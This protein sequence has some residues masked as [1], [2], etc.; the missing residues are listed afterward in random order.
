MKLLILGAGNAQLNAI[1]RAKERGHTVIV[2][3]YYANP[4]G[5]AIADYHEQVST[6]DV[7]GNI[8]VAKKYEIDGIMA[9][10][11]DQPVYTVAVVAQRLKLPAFWMVPLRKQ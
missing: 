7:E 1:F 10:G 2:S 8:A 6:F 3:D 4:P 11:T 5:K 9:L